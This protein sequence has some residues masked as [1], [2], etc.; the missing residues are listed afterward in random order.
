MK[1]VTLEKFQNELGATV[2]E[3]VIDISK[4]KI[5]SK[6]FHL[7]TKAEYQEHFG[8][9]KKNTTVT[10]KF[11]LHRS[12]IEIAINQGAYVPDNVLSDYPDLKK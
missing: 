2:G 9:P 4:R 10:G 7:M 6:P 11:S 1:I 8:L 5:S 3:L 12:A